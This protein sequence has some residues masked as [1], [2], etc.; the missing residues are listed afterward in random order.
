MSSGARERANEL[1][2]V[3]VQ[4]QQCGASKCVSS[5]RERVSEWPSF[6]HVNVIVILS[7]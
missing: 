1:S 5:A 7:P 6:Q 2:G 4:S 3:R